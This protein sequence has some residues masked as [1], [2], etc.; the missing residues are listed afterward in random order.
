MSQTAGSL[1]P[2]F[3]ATV[4][5]NESALTYER[6]AKRRADTAVQREHPTAWQFE[7]RGTSSLR[8]FYQGQQAD[9]Q[10]PGANNMLSDAVIAGAEGY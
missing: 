7:L 6:T 9:C 2:A 8:Q 4:G 1:S 3:Q 5:L 10:Q